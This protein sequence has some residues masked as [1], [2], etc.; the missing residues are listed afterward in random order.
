[1]TDLPPASSGQPLRVQAYRAVAGVT[2]ATEVLSPCGHEVMRFDHTPGFE[3]VKQAY[4]RP[5]FPRSRLCPVCQ[6]VPATG[7]VARV[8]G[9]TQLA[10]DWGGLAGS[11]RDEW[12]PLL[13]TALQNI[14]NAPDA[15]RWKVLTP[16]QRATV[17][18]AG[19]V[20]A[21]RFG[22]TFHELLSLKLDPAPELTAAGYDRLTSSGEDKARRIDQRER[23]L[24]QAYWAS[25]RG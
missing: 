13:N 23:R 14:P 20:L 9:P 5:M 8:S 15:T 18:L 25:K 2:A 16:A 7:V 17:A 6:R 12:A 22:L 4:G 3:V 1:M 11:L 10:A 24:R 19:E 21:K